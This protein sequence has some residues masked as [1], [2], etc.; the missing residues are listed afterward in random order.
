[1]LAAVAVEGIGKEA[2]DALKAAFPAMFVHRRDIGAEYFQVLGAK[3]LR[4]AANVI[5]A[6]FH[7]A[8]LPFLFVADLGEEADDEADIGETGAAA[9]AAATD[10]AEPTA[11]ELLGADC[12]GSCPDEGD[13]ALVSDT[14]HGDCN[15]NENCAPSSMTTDML[16]QV[17]MFAQ[18]HADALAGQSLKVATVCSMFDAWQARHCPGAKKLDWGV[19]VRRLVGHCGAKRVA[20]GLCPHLQFAPVP[21][22]GADRDGTLTAEEGSADISPLHRFLDAD[23]S[24]T[25]TRAKLIYVR[26]EPGAVTPW[27]EFKSTFQAYMRYKYPT[28]KYDEP[29]A[30]GSAS[31]LQALGYEVRHVHLCKACGAEGG[32]CCEHYHRANRVMQWR[33]YNLRLVKEVRRIVM[34]DDLSD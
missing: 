18:H 1:M 27:I 11:P 5:C 4:H 22:E 2:E 13:A 21:G 34:Q 3:S 17:C 7:A 25:S 6:S 12:D 10:A 14:G 24:E 31:V 30:K 32:S 29:T 8:V 20:V 15:P 23:P 28:L 33:I 16:Q 19:L 26:H 9:A